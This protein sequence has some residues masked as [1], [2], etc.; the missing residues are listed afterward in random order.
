[1]LASGTSVT[2]CSDYDDEI[3]NLQTQ[4]DQITSSNPVTADDIK[5]AVDAAK[6]DLQ[7]QLDELEQQLAGSGDDSGLAAKVQELERKIAELDGIKNRLD[8]LELA[9]K[10]Y[11]ETGSLA[12]YQAKEGLNAFINEKITD[13][14]DGNGGAI[15]AYIEEAVKTGALIDLNRLNAELAAIVGPAGSLTLL[16]ADFEKYIT[17]NG[18]EALL[19]RVSGL[20]S[21]AAY[22]EKFIENGNGQYETFADV[23]DQIEETRTLAASLFVP[24][25]EAYNA[26]Q[27]I[28]AGEIG[29]VDSRIETI[30]SDIEKLGIDVEAIKGMIQSIV[31]V[32]AYADGKVQF[33]TLYAEPASGSDWDLISSSQEVEVKFRISP[34]SAVQNFVKNY[35]VEI[36]SLE[37]ESRADEPLAVKEGSVVVADAD[38]GIVAMKLSADNLTGNRAACL[39]VTGKRQE[40]ASDFV[41]DVTSDY[42]DVVAVEKYMKN[43][44][45]ETAETE[46]ELVYNA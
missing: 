10:E 21:Y 17:G 29:A 1:M 31:Y 44:K 45:Y 40:G 9:E 46:R 6:G 36:Q 41:S 3:Q 16:Q 37:V 2:S 5:A 25:G 30:E 4:I 22:I 43:V 39:H 32:P 35:E 33:T 20:E 8:E 7:K 26:V 11:A 23:L 19:K 14:L 28:V 24:G 12:A 27:A 18:D 42:F 13:A 38:L 34:A 15:A